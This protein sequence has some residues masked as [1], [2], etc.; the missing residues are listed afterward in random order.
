MYASRV[1]PFVT[2]A[3]GGGIGTP[4]TAAGGSGTSSHMICWRI[5]RPRLVGEGSDV[6]A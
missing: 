1:V 6:C 2:V 4:P 5:R 3:G